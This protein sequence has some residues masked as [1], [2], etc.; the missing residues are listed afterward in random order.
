MAKEGPVGQRMTEEQAFKA[1]I[2]MIQWDLGNYTIDN[3]EL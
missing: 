2:E 3:I 1:A